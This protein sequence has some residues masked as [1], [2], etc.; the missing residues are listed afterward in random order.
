MASNLV[1]SSVTAKLDGAVSYSVNVGDDDMTGLMLVFD[2]DHVFGGQRVELESATGLIKS[3]TKGILPQIQPYKAELLHQTLSGTISN[4]AIGAS[5]MPEFDLQLSRDSY[6]AIE[7]SGTTSVHV[8]Q[9]STSDTS[10]LNNTAIE[11]GKSIT[12]RGF[13]YGVDDNRNVTS[14][15]PLHFAMVATSFS[16]LHD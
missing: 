7:N 4:Y 9:R 12:V 10:Q 2:Q 5:G 11:D 13:L 16:K 6:L 14:G 3:G 15:V 1:G 8:Y